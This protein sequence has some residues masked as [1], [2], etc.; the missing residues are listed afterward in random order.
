LPQDGVVIQVWVG[1]SGEFDR[2]QVEPILVN[3]LGEPCSAM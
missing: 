2:D 1:E 3:E